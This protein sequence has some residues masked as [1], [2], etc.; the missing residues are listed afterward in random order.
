MPE[1]DNS[2]KPD[3]EKTDVGKKDTDQ[4]SNNQLYEVTIDGEKRNLTLDELK[5]FASKAA[6]ADKKFNEAS[7]LRKS[8]EKGVRIMSL[9]ESLTENP[10]ESDA[11]DL[12][13]ILGIDANEFYQY[14]TEDEGGNESKDS[15]GDTKKAAKSKTAKESVVEGL[16]ELGLDPAEVK[17]ILDY[18][19][20]RHIED[21]RKEIREISDEAVDKDEVF[22]KIKIDEKNKERM[23]VIKDLVAEDVLRRIQDGV[24]FGADLVSASI[25]K[26]RSYITKFGIPSKPEQYPV[27]LGLIPGGGLPAEVQA[28]EPIKRTSADKDVGEEN[29]VA[30]FMQRGLKLLRE[31]AGK[32]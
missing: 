3:D 24:P 27:S 13:N 32:K 10:T 17:A 11:K 31:G 21:A 22:G 19:H 1:Q 8:G 20:K 16:K 26:I 30:R 6:G 25:Q 4:S 15:E 14:L 2:S 12:A 28:E 9:I 29:L 5:T 23:S 18:S 7:E